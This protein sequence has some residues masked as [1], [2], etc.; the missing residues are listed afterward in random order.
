MRGPR[1][2][3]AADGIPRRGGGPRGES[4]GGERRPV[5]LLAEGRSGRAGPAGPYFLQEPRESPLPALQGPSATRTPY[6]PHRGRHG[7]HSGRVHAVAGPH[8]FGGQPQ[9]QGRGQPRTGSASYTPSG[10]ARR[11]RHDVAADGTYV[12]LPGQRDLRARSAGT[13]Q[14]RAALGQP[15]PD[16]HPS[17]RRTYPQGRGV[18]A[19]VGPGPVRGQQRQGVVAAAESGQVDPLIDGDTGQQPLPGGHGISMCIDVDDDEPGRPAGDPDP[20]LGLGRPPGL[21][22]TEVGGG[23]MESVTPT[24]LGTAHAILRRMQTAPAAGA[25][26]SWRLGPWGQW[27]D[28]IPA[29]GHPGRHVQCRPATHALGQVLG[30][31]GHWLFLDARSGT[32]PPVPGCSPRCSSDLHIRDQRD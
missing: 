14:A 29:Q 28:R 20:E 16:V 31:D 15:V 5:E 1:P 4:S 32:V 25:V 24:S 3:G 21:Q 18:F 7:L 17:G 13:P 12:D 9:R 30:I 26:R 8:E 22:R 27:M 6:R 23:R 10:R 19:G 11:R 2:R